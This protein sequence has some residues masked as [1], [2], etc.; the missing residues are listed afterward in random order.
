MLLVGGS[1]LLL[2]CLGVHLAVVGRDDEVDWFLKT[3]ANSSIHS[4]RST[5]GE[6]AMQDGHLTDG[7]SLARHSLIVERGLVHV[8]ELP[9]L[10]DVVAELY[11]KLEALLL[12]GVSQGSLVDDLAGPRADALA[13]VEPLQCGSAD[14]NIALLE[15]LNSLLDREG[16]PVFEQLLRAQQ[17]LHV[18]H[19]HSELR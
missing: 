16:A 3:G 8:D 7:P 5:C 2:A 11:R 13:P 17:A 19:Q 9:L 6:Y 1:R 10:D 12:V 14:L 15:H 18:R 4:R